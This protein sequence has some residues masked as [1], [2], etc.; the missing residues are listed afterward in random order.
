[1]YRLRRLYPAEDGNCATLVHILVLRLSNCTTKTVL[2]GLLFVGPEE[3]NQ[4]RFLL[5][6]PE[7]R[8]VLIPPS[9]PP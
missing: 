6:N 3:Q 8:S 7:T 4:V 2:G 9:P 5:F 1:M